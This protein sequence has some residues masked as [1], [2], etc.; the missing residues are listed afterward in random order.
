MQFIHADIVYIFNNYLYREFYSK[1]KDV[2]MNIINLIVKKGFIA[3]N[4]KKM[5]Q[6]IRVIVIIA[7]IYSNII[8]LT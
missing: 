5:F 3:Q 7:D 4:N 1:I 2:N 8:D 6:L